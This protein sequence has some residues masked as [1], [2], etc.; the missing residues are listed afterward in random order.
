MSDIDPGGLMLVL[1]A[2]A[3]LALPTAAGRRRFAGVFAVRSARR[4]LPVRVPMRAA[5][6][7]GCAAAFGFGSGG[8]MAALLVAATVTTR[9]R[10]TRAA[11][12]HRAECGH[13]LDGL[14]A[15][16]AELRVGA[17]P[18]AAA[19][20]AARETTGIAASAF[21]VG[22]ARSRLGG[23]GAEGLLRPGSAIGPELA[24]VAD[25]WR[26]AERYGLA[27]AELLAATR[28]DL[29][30]RIAF[31]SRTD[32]ALA[33]ARATAAILA[34]LPVLGIGLGQLMGADPLRVLLFS[35]MGTYLLPLGTGLACAGLLWADEITRRVVPR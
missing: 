25:A 26:V 30:A 12:L 5:T 27:L 19:A 31:R 33:G 24:R 8:L 10:R 7:L 11:R 13:L 34:V 6:A 4:P 20:A 16:I 32:A 17:H 28:A 18:G 3:L 22:A 15:V 35:S 1:V 2:A 14:E 9:V 23:S 29:A 21:A